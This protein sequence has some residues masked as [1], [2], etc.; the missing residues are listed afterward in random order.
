[1][2]SVSDC[3]LLSLAGILTLL[4]LLQDNPAVLL[5]VL[6]CIK[7]L[8]MEANTLDPLQRAGFIPKL[9]SFLNFTAGTLVTEMH[10]QVLNA[11]YNLCKLNRTRQE[12]AAL[13]GIVPHLKNIIVANRY[14]VPFALCGCFS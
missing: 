6:K 11:L 13:A 7:F 1:M 3:V 8:S 5:K 4:D 2:L 9:V 10:S 12:Q 14:P